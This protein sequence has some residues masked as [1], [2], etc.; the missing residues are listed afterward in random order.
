MQAVKE[1]LQDMSAMRKVKAEAKAE[2]KAEKDIAKARMNIAHEVRLAREAEAEMELHVAKAA[3]KAD[4]EI[5]KHTPHHTTNAP[6][7]DLP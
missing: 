5:A 7:P 1:K 4:K 2:E 3:D 6:G